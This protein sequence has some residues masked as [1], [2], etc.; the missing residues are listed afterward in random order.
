MSVLRLR[1]SLI[2]RSAR[3]RSSA[4]PGRK[5]FCKNNHTQ[6]GNCLPLGLSPCRRP[7]SL[8]GRGTELTAARTSF[9]ASRLQCCKLRISSGLCFS[10]ELQV[11]FKNY[12]SRSHLL[13]A[14]FLLLLLRG[15]LLCGV[16]LRGM[17]R[18]VLSVELRKKRVAFAARPN[19]APSR[20]APAPSCLP[21]RGEPGAPRARPPARLPFPLCVPLALGA[22]ESAPGDAA[23]VRLVGRAPSPKAGGG[24]GDPAAPQSSDSAG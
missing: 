22:E 13:I 21:A 23:A 10:W 14:S 6:P 15:T 8:Q 4:A 18:V 20:A 16:F 24:V 3:E 5:Q 17:L 7:H 12:S 9:P 2:L 11:H 19:P 1:L